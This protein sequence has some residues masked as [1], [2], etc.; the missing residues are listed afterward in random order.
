MKIPMHIFAK[1]SVLLWKCKF[2]SMVL[3]KQPLML[4]HFFGDFLTYLYLTSYWLKNSQSRIFLD[5]VLFCVLALLYSKNIKISNFLNIGVSSFSKF[6]K[7]KKRKKKF[8]FNQC[9]RLKSNNHI[10]LSIW[11]YQRAILYSSTVTQSCQILFNL[12]ICL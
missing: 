9:G 8:H 7:T 4:F 10:W 2:C 3:T 5:T 12:H 6:I 1:I 11:I